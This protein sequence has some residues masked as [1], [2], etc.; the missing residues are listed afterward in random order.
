MG[1]RKFHIQMHD[2]QVIETTE[3]WHQGT[4]PE[5]FRERLPDNANFLNGAGKVAVGDDYCFNSSNCV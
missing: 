1:G 5:H 3:L 2:G 4:I